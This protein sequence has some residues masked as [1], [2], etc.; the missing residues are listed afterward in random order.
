MIDRAPEMREAVNA[1]RLRADWRPLFGLTL[2]DAGSFV[3]RV[4]ARAVIG[5]AVEAHNRDVE[6]ANK[7]AK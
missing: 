1:V 3:E 5:A 7:K 4:C 2:E 6:R